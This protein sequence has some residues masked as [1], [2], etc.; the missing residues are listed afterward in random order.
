MKNLFSLILFIC[1][2]AL[3]AQQ[4]AKPVFKETTVSGT[5]TNAPGKKLYLENFE[6]S[7]FASRM[8]STII[9]KK[10]KFAFKM[11]IDKTNYYRFAFQSNDFFVLIL[12]PGEKVT[13]I[14]DGNRMNQSYKVVGSEHSVKLQDFVKLVNDYIQERDSIQAKV[15]EFAQ[16]GDQNN[17]NI[18][19][20]ELNNAY[21]RFLGNRD[22]FLNDNPA[23]PALLGVL[24]HLNQN[25][26]IEQMRKIENALGASMPGSAFH[27]SVKSMRMN[28]EAK[29]AEEERKRKEQEEFANRLAPG[30]L[31]PPIEMNDANG[32]L[33]PLS[34]LKGKVVLIDFWASWCGPCRKE[35]PNVVRVYN[36]YKDKGF[37]IYSVSIDQSKENWLAAIEKD[38]LSWPSHVSTLQGWQTPI[39]RDYGVNGVPFTVLIDRDGKIIQAN[40]RGPMLEAKLAEIFGF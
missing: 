31:A 5:I 9:N 21:T 24:N 28:L 22:K 26:D 3:Q 7:G 12:Q 16:Q 29:L 10:G 11:K 34:S 35:N 2:T 6:R 38:Q 1:C 40:L 20:T 15:K 23:S 4:P 18:A 19:N 33:L 17:A 30:K 32:K 13:V 25:Q 27:E 14:A 39:L 36:K 8:D 37:T